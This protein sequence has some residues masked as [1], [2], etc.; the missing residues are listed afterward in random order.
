MQRMLLIGLFVITL[1]VSGFSPVEAQK[2]DDKKAPAPQCL[3]L[4]ESIVLESE[5]EVTSPQYVTKVNGYLPIRHYQRHSGYVFGVGDEF[6][7]SNTN[8]ARANRLMTLA[9]RTESSVHYGEL[10]LYSNFRLY[11]LYPDTDNTVG[12]STNRFNT[13]YT[14]TLDANNIIVNGQT[15]EDYIESVVENM[16]ANNIEPKKE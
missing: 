11:P 6:D 2:T 9:Y 13:V 14:K 3:T 12:T 10:Q 5:T 1:F 15:L 4:D 7:P 8:E 16:E